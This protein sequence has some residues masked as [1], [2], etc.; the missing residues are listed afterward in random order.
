MSDLELL[1]DVFDLKNVFYRNTTT[2][3][4]RCLAGELNLLPDGDNRVLLEKDYLN[5]QEAGMLN[6]HVYSMAQILNELSA[7]QKQ[8]NQRRSP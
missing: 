8:I 2:H 4:E 1:A 5:M 6:G 3:S 7:L